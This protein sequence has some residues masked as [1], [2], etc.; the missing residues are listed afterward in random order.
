MDKTGENI[1][2]GL[3][4]LIYLQNPRKVM[5]FILVLLFGQ[6]FHAEFPIYFLVLPVEN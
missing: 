2:A 5:E 1:S 4:L 3:L 6:N